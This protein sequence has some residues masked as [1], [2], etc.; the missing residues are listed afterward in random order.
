[1]KSS[2]FTANFLF[3][4]SVLILASGCTSIRPVKIKQTLLPSGTLLPR[5]AVLVL[6]QALKDYK[7]E[8]KY[9]IGH[10]SVYPFGKALP[11]YAESVTSECFQQ[12][13]VVSSVEEAISVTN[14][15]LI[16]IPRVVK[17]EH[18]MLPVWAWEDI[19]FTFVVAW[20]AKD[21]TG[22]NTLWF[23]TITA[24]SSEPLGDGFTM[25]R[26]ELILEQKLFDDLSLKTFKAM[27]RAMELKN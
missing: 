8:W 25:N 1:M 23:K 16:L 4:F 12:V 3:I 14:A 10:T 15:N 20:T 7:Y 19:D 6:D 26:N 27:Q 24:E 18:S 17:C 11:D 9:G 5:H 21:K 22:Q 13:D 2:R